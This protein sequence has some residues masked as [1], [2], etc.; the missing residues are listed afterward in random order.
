MII[1]KHSYSIVVRSSP[2]SFWSSSPKSSNPRKLKLLMEASSSFTSQPL[3]RW[4][5]SC[6]NQIFTAMFWLSLFAI[7]FTWWY[8]NSIKFIRKCFWNISINLARYINYRQLYKSY[9]HYIDLPQSPAN[10]CCK[11]VK[12][13]YSTDHTIQLSVT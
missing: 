1:S 12:T 2:S 9:V 4:L 10:T 13:I 6:L 5:G 3:R 11:N 7:E 8:L